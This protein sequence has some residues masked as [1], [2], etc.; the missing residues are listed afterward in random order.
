MRL[1]AE[2]AGQFDFT[3]PDTIVNLT[4]G[5]VASERA[6]LQAR[7]SDFVSRREGAQRVMDEATKE[8]GL[9]ETF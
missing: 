5:V 9:L 3:V 6:L 4:P 1:E 7:Q 8:R 2:L